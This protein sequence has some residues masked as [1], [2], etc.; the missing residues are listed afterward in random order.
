[1]AEQPVRRLRAVVS[2]QVPWNGLV[3]FQS[4]FAVLQ[5]SMRSLLR[6]LVMNVEDDHGISRKVVENAP[7]FTFVT[8]AKLTGIQRCD[9]WIYESSNPFGRTYL[10]RAIQ[11]PFHIG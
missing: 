7:G 8:D 5:D 2:F 1:M 11:Q 10:E 6:R 9:S 4:A 3:E